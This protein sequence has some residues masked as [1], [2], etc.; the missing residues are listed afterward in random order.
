MCNFNCVEFCLWR[1]PTSLLIVLHVHYLKFYH[2]SWVL[3][4]MSN[5]LCLSGLL[6]LINTSE[7]KLSTSMCSLCI[8]LLEVCATAITVDTAY[9]CCMWF[10]IQISFLWVYVWHS[11]NKWINPWHIS[12]VYACLSIFD[13]LRKFVTLA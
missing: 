11:Y 13:K 10:F 5:V 9:L 12:A 6:C 2:L 1:F 7:M 4:P 8:C 3:F